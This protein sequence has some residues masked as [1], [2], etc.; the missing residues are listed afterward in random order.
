MTK[1]TV[2]S[3]IKLS[4]DQRKQLADVLSKKYNVSEFVEKV[5]PSILGGLKI[6]IGST[7]L[8]F[9]IKNKLDALKK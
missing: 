7:Q 5:D 1:T 9:S 6:T 8:D 4:A 3:A 2:I